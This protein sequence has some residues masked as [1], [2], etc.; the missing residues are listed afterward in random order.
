MN[1]THLPDTLDLLIDS[2]LP[3]IRKVLVD[4]PD[5]G[6]VGLALTFHAGRLAKTAVSRTVL[7]L[8][9]QSN[10]IEREHVAQAKVKAVRTKEGSK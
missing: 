3:E 8:A 9:P 6:E 2:V 7:Q 10:A 1:N 5:Y 4:A